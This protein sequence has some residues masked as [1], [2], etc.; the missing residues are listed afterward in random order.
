MIFLNRF[1]SAK[2]LLIGM[3]TSGGL[4]EDNACLTSPGTSH[5]SQY[6]APEMLV[7]APNVNSLHADIWS[8]GVVLYRMLYRSLPFESRENGIKGWRKSDLNNLEYSEDVIEVLNQM[9]HVN[10]SERDIRKILALPWF[11]PFNSLT[12]AMGG[13]SPGRYLKKQPHH[14]APGD[15][16]HVSSQ[17]QQYFLNYPSPPPSTSSDS[18]Y[19]PQTAYPSAIN[20]PQLRVNGFDQ[21]IKRST[22]S[23]SSSEPSGVDLSKS[24]KENHG[25]LPNRA[26]ESAPI[27]MP[28]FCIPRRSAPPSSSHAPSLIH[29]HLQ[30]ST[31]E[32]PATIPCESI[33]ARIQ[34][35]TKATSATP[36]S[37]RSSRNSSPLPLSTTVTRHFRSSTSDDDEQEEVD[38]SSA[39]SLFPSPPVDTLYWK[40]PKH[41]RAENG[42]KASRAQVDLPSLDHAT[43]ASAEV[44]SNNPERLPS[45]REWV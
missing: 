21:S 11:Y 7:N 27:I 33:P 37:T 10:P 8:L 16:I 4:L 38:A 28:P 39:F 32:S 9:L 42:R 22:V 25:K 20:T 31:N 29:D 45:F 35:S 6:S 18:F 34:S 44:I 3:E 13:R 14:L 36:N 40:S 19:S 17:A 24:A 2:V 26:F 41:L 15:T 30:T 12:L 43:A 23:S 1:G 5:L